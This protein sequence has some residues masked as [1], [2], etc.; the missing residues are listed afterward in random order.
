[1]AT[2]TTVTYKGPNDFKAWFNNYK[3]LA[4]INDL[5]TLCNPLSTV[6]WP[7]EPLRPSMSLYNNKDGEMEEVPLE[8]RQDWVEG[9]P[10]PRRIRG[11]RN[12]DELT[13]ANYTLYSRRIDMYIIDLINWKSKK[14]SIK[15][16][17]K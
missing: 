2:P 9:N 5:W 7:T 12:T 4:E 3:S 16:F 10:I 6:P 17:T 13:A 15:E 14:E 11:A 8:D 1:M